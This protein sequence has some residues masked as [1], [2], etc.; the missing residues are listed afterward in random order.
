[1][2]PRNGTV[3]P[4][5]ERVAKKSAADVDVEE[6][7]DPAEMQRLAEQFRGLVKVVGGPAKAAAILKRSP[8]T[9]HSWMTSKTKI[10]FLVIFRLT[11]AADLSLDAFAAGEEAIANRRDVTALAR[12]APLAEGFVTV[13]VLQVTASAGRGRITVPDDLDEDGEMVAFREAWLRSLGLTPGRVHVLW[14]AGDSMV[15]TINNGDMLLVDR[16]ID[17]V[18]DDGIYVVV[19][20]GGVLVKRIQ[21]RHNGSVVLKSD[22]DRYDA[23][24]IPGD[25]V[26]QLVIEGRVRWVGGPI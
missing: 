7:E 14:A 16:M 23:Q 5:S 26:P 24:T 11:Q 17:R 10:P 15:P 2:D 20:G 25:E 21:L 19:V 3:N 4:G 6:I 13:P 12:G 18:V 9:I 8:N 1:M 22:N